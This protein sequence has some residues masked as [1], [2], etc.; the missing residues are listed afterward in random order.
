MGLL[1][2]GQY[3]VQPLND[4][5]RPQKGAGWQSGLDFV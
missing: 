3:F 1:P 4:L 5:K 2:K